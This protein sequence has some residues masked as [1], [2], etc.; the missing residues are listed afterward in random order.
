MRACVRAWCLRVC[1]C[2]CVCEMPGAYELPKVAKEH[3]TRFHH[4]TNYVTFLIK[5]L[6]VSRT[7]SIRR[8][9]VRFCFLYMETS[10]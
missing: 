5:L 4:N 8:R 3:E 6:R 10:R 1:V 9:L 7:I 2:V